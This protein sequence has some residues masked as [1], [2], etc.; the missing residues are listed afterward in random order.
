[1]PSIPSHANAG[2]ASSD[3]IKQYESLG[4]PWIIPDGLR[5]EMQAFRFVPRLARTLRAQEG[6]PSDDV[7]CL[8]TF[9]TNIY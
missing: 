6:K 1:M 7:N 2:Q 3:R 9:H 5:H 4:F 8:A